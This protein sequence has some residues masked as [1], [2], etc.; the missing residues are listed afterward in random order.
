MD[1]KKLLSKDEANA[2]IGKRIRLRRTTIGLS[3]AALA[4]MI[5]V[6]FQQV[7]KYERG[8]NSITAHRLVQL[9]QLLEV[10]A[11][12]FLNDIPIPSAI[13]GDISLE[14]DNKLSNRET[15][16]IIKAFNHLNNSM[17]RRR[18]LDLVRSVTD[19]DAER[20]R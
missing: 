15:L 4:S 8:S 7:Q 17:F 18:I 13:E 11:T 14:Y 9:A 2:Y 1:S 20:K 16:E 19:D 6:T 10:P 12:Y 5:G 3:Q